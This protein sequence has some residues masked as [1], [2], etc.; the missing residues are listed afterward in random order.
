MARQRE[1]Q[2]DGTKATAGR[3]QDVLRLAKLSRPQ[4]SSAFPRLRLFKLLNETSTKP[5][6]WIHGP[7][8]A[9][10]TTLVASYLSAHRI[11]GIWY[12]IDR[13]DADLA[14]FF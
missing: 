2:K 10:K 14:G 1:T 11:S 4:L 9:G 7:P 3:R 5:L 13:D 8:G 12:Q 6:M